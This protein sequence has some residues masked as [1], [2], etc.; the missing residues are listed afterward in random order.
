[1]R[2]RRAL[3]LGLA[4]LVI[5]LAVTDAG[6]A[7]LADP[8]PVPA[9]AVLVG[10]GDIASCSGSGD[11]ATAKLVDQIPGTVFTVGDNAYEKGTASDFSQCYGPTWGRFKSRTRPAAGNHEYQTSG[12]KP[13]Y[14]YFGAAAGDRTQGW[15]SYEAGAWHVVVLNSNCGP[16]GGC[17]AGSPQERWLRA[18][19]AAAKAECIAAVWHEPRFSSAYGNSSSTKPFW[20]ALYQFGADVIVNGHHHDYER[21]APQ[22]PDG[23]ADPRGVR[24]FIV[25][26]GGRSLT[27]SFQ[28]TARNSEIR[29]NTTYGVMK[30]TLRA[31]GYDWEFVSVAGKTF[32]DSGSSGCKNSGTPNPE[33]SG[34]TV[35]AAADARVAQADPKANFGS[36]T[37]MTADASPVMSCLI[38]FDT[39]G[40]PGPV[41]KA[42][43]RLYVNNGSPDGPSLYPNDPNWLETGVTWESRPARLGPAAG[44][45]ARVNSG[46]WV[47]YDVTSLVTGNVRPSFELSSVS[48]DGT[49][50]NT[51]EA[52]ANRPQ[53]VV[54]TAP[55]PTTTTSTTTTSTTA[56]SSTTITTI[57]TM[58]VTTEPPGPPPGDGVAG[59]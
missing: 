14:D 49:G 42:T 58:P 9:P 18:D 45:L 10:A 56:T 57:T 28:T 21:F 3:V 26:T 19:L 54:T 32:R 53:L 23:R 15:Y 51:K 43:L 25:G 22:D 34:T 29:N 31:D 20:D 35:F 16:V 11:E 17:G 1:M 5:P 39:S 55:A 47:E 33:P 24:E 6:Q 8:V 44:D 27:S 36:A 2:G 30:L 38:R 48:T 7:L 52:G 50:F 40:L 4:A 59:I 13:Y 41:T 46:T 37:A 12:A